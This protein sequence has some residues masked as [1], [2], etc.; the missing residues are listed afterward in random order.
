MD[1]TPKPK[2]RTEPARQAHARSGS[3]KPP[4]PARRLRHSRRTAAGVPPNEESPLCC[5]F[6]PPPPM[7]PPPDSPAGR[8]PLLAPALQRGHVRRRRRRPPQNLRELRFM[9]GRALPGPRQP[10]AR[11]RFVTGGS[12]GRLEEGEGRGRWRRPAHA[13]R[14]AVVRVEE[15]GAE[16]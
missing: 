2:P 1:V 7:P 5:S 13:G 15:E 9:G 10:I 6:D 8:P 12:G 16:E 4:K 11:R 3:L 14:C